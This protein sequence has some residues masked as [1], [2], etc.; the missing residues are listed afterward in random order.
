MVKS[1]S[2]FLNA[3]ANER[4]ANNQKFDG[5]FEKPGHFSIGVVLVI[6]FDIHFAKIVGCDLDLEVTCCEGSKV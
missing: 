2:S 3:T 1:K 6:H 4:V 5:D